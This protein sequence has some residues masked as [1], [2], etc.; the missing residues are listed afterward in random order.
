MKGLPPKPRTQPAS[1]QNTGDFSKKD[2]LL[3]LRALNKE[4]LVADHERFKPL[5]HSKRDF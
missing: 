4:H 5:I 2:W 3:T 1:T